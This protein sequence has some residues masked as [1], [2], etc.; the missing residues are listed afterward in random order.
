MSFSLETKGLLLD[1]IHMILQNSSV[2]QG[3]IIVDIIRKIK[4]LMSEKQEIQLNDISETA[5]LLL[6]PEEK[7][8]TFG[9]IRLCV[10]FQ[11]LKIKGQN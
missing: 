8:V 9:N 6:Y 11:L 4:P 5:Q 3:I 2:D 7:T 1:R 10:N